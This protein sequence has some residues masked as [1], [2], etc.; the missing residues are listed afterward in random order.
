MK[1]MLPCKVELRVSVWR[2]R[3]P[4]QFLI[5]VEAALDAVG[6]KGLDATDDKACMEEKECIKKLDEANE[7]L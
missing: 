4:K 1:P 5:H 3:T 2:H 6:Q 7:D